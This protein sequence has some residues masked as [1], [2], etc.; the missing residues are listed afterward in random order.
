MGGQQRLL[1]CLLLELLRARVHK[2]AATCPWLSMP[3]LTFQGRAAPSRQWLFIPRPLSPHAC[4][5]CPV[6]NPQFLFALAFYV[7][8]T[9]ALLAGCA[10]G[11]ARYKADTFLEFN[12]ELLDTELRSSLPLVDS[13]GG[14]SRSGQLGMASQE[15]ADRAWR[16]IRRCW[17][18]R[19]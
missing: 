12:S 8:I 9:V 13:M 1:P 7:L 16:S 17:P 5:T 19:A 15:T 3:S 4:N 14:W 2:Y 10:F 6:C 11:A 18:G